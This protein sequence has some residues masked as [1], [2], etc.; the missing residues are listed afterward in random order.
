MKKLFLLLTVSSLALVSCKKDN[1]LDRS[2][3]FKGPT[4][5]FQEGLAW[6]WVQLSKTGTPEKIGISIDAKAMSTLDPG[7]DHD[8]GH[9]H[10]NNLSLAFHQKA[11]A[12]PFKHVMLDWNPHGHEPAGVY[13]LAHFD[14]HFYMT[15]EAERLAIPL[16]E[17]DSLKF[18]N[19]PAPGYMPA[20]YFPIPGGVPQ[21]GTHWLDMNAPEINGQ[22]FSQTF[23]YGSYD[24]K[25]TFYEPMITKAFLD[26]NQAFVRDI[27]VPTKFAADG[28]YP[29][30]MRITKENGITSIIL[31]DF[32]YRTKS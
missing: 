10:A 5:K 9:N 21:M 11:S 16:Y 24:G 31:E 29:T 4:E 19:L 32:V 22:V 25:V 13:D 20:T 27:A 3:I 23:L 28:Y 12:T 18:K 7:T 26:A 30:A 6:T 8:G 15:T 14:F 1:D 17:Q 2:G